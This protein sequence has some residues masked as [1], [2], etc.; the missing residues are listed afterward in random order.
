MSGWN[1]RSCTLTGVDQWTD[2]DRLS[3]LSRRYTFAEWGV[4][5][6]PGRQG[7]ENRYPSISGC[8]WGVRLREMRWCKMALHVCGVGVNEVLGARTHWLEEWLTGFGRVQLNL[9]GDRFSGEM[10][11]E[12]VRK[13]RQGA[14]E[15][16]VIVQLNDL[17]RPICE[18]L[19]GVEGVEFLWDSSGG[20]GVKP[21][22][23]AIWGD[24]A[25]SKV[26]QS[27]WGYAGGLG[28]E[29]VASELPEIG[30][31]SGG[32]PFWIDMEQKLRDQNDRFDLTKA[33]A[34]LDMV[35]KVSGGVELVGM[36][37]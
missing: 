2:L 15:R 24:G 29:N 1:L 31:A 11:A 28:P 26:S 22:G 4:L 33:E 16:R 36:T 35:E 27:L 7:L 30:F 3:W 18:E 20:R 19:N 13:I 14:P 10:I 23:W 37:G 6:S 32:R 25:H 21:H 34:V 12:G 17:N 9:R 5:Y 8:D